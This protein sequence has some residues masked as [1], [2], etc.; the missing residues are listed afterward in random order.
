MCKP[1]AAR[2]TKNLLTSFRKCDKPAEAH[3]I[4][5]PGTLRQRN[6][7]PTTGLDMP[8]G[9]QEVKPARI[10]RQQ[11][12]EGVK[13]V[14]STNWPPLPLPPG[15]TTGIYFCQRLSRAHGHGAAGRVKLIKY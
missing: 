9:F 12:Y 4:F 14:N 8:L 5:H 7:Y 10:Y 11:A 15:D 2:L 6:S 1:N 13:V 3:G